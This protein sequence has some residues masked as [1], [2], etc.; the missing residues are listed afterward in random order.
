MM[1]HSRSESQYAPFH[2]LTERENDILKLLME[3]LTD[4][5]IAARLVVAYTTIKWYNRQIFNKLGVS[6]RREATELARE[7]D[8]FAA[9]DHDATPRHN[10]PGQTTP[11]IGRSSELADLGHL[12]DN[13]TI[14]LV[15]ILAPGGMGKTRLALAAAQQ[16]LHLYRDGVFFVP[17][18]ALN[19]PD[20][21][22]PSLAQQTGYPFQRDQ[23]SQLQQMLDY[24]SDKRMLLVLDNFEQVLDGAHLVN[25]IL[26]AAPRL[27]II[28]TSR[29]RLNVKGETVFALDSMSFPL[30]PTERPL[31]YSAVQL[32]VQCAQRARPDYSLNGIDD[33]IR[34]CR[35][36]QGMPLGIE[37]AAAWLE[38]LSP[39]QIADEIA[40]G[41]DFL[42]T[43]MRD[44]PERQRSVR[45]VYESS[46]RRLTDEERSAFMN[47]SVFRGGCT[48]RA[49]LTVARVGLHT[50]S[51]LVDKALVKW[52]PDDERYVTHEL[53]RQ[54]AAE[55]LEQ[56]GL[57]EDGLAAHCAYYA[58]Q[59][60]LREPDLKGAGQLSALQDITAD[61]ENVKAAFVW[62]VE[63]EQYAHA[64][65][66]G[67]SL[68]LFYY[69]S[70]R[71][72][73]G[74]DFMSPST[75]MLRNRHDREA[76]RLLGRVLAWL[77]VFRSFAWQH[78]QVTLCLQEALEIA[79]EHN[80]RQQIA[81]CLPRLAIANRLAQPDLIVQYCQESIRICRELDDKYL[82]AFAYHALGYFAGQDGDLDA[83]HRW[84]LEAATLRREI[85]D[86]NGL[87][88]SLVNLCDHAQRCGRWDLAEQYSQECQSICEQLGDIL[89]VTANLRN[90]VAQSLF[91]GDF[92][93][94]EA[95]I[96]FGLKQ[97]NIHKQL[98]NE[99]A[100][101]FELS[102]LCLLQASYSDALRLAQ[103]ALDK[104]TLLTSDTQQFER[105]YPLLALGCASVGLGKWEAAAEHL[106]HGMK[107]A[108]TAPADNV[109]Q[110]YALTGFAA[111]FAHDV[112]PERAV[113]LLSLAVNH[114][115]SPRW[116]LEREPLTGKLIDQLQQALPPQAYAE[117]WARGSALDLDAVTRELVNEG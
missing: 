97:S 65:Q 79:Y 86:K 96:R 28:V 90:Q 74:L 109:S 53:L 7:L 106:R 14:R 5:E 10:L 45:A 20:D 105:G 71:L 107:W 73:E 27:Q 16:R 80:D 39:Q 98:A 61:L 1:I 77:G 113:E 18:V 8:L 66:I 48:R 55:A 117:A 36:T 40:L 75:I 99:Q 21:I 31:E 25:S 110:R 100:F 103:Q 108:A 46:W 41:L 13:Q 44:I 32:F 33:V 43:R 115:L 6:S 12:L 50:L 35:L 34:V 57:A 22:I 58:E 15:T 3:G 60:A 94:A 104:G 70:G 62:A 59:I 112:Q 17:L 49:A 63:H 93:Q 87:T 88:R 91:K 89:I 68:G 67:S 56:A 4:R 24:L 82:M 51:S 84:T 26:E 69:T 29:E 95:R 2:Q 78:E 38:V 42:S 102:L 9:A 101:L 72:Y 64:L 83:Y 111:L 11:F 81:L 47:L 37:L 23:R 52:L 116:W 76:Q 114:P 92:H 85:G 30:E 19:S 54:Y